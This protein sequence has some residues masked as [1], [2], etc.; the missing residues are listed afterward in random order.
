MSIPSVFLPEQKLL[1][2]GL[3]LSSNIHYQLS[4]EELTEQTVNR[5]QGQL[6][7]TGALC[8]HTGKFTGRSPKD[9]F[10]VQDAITTDTV[11]W[12]E[13]NNP[14]DEKYF[15]I[16]YKKM[17]DFLGTKE[18][19]WVRDSYVC[20]DK[21]YRLNIRVVNENAWSNLF[22]YNLFLRPTDEELESFE[23]DWHIIQAP[24]FFANPETDGVR[25]SLIHI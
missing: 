12:N 24:S 6:N 4:P 9:K 15:H 14:I 3:K 18:E 8:I 19:I 13:F 1:K 25:L 17:M 16:L 21:N 11:H 20:A 10:I 7:N 2:L 22:A 23:P 5:G